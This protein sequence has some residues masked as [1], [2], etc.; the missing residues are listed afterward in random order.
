[1]YTYFLVL[2]F[3]PLRVQNKTS[4]LCVP[5]FIKKINLTVQIINIS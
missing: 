3:F 4:I 5:L 1:M 2:Y